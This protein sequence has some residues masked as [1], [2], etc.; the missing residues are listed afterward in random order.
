MSLSY[1]TGSFMFEVFLF[2]VSCCS[3]WGLRLV[4]FVKPEM[5]SLVNRVKQSSVKTGIANTLGLYIFLYFDGL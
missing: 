1:P 3:L 4:V 5:Y 2:Q